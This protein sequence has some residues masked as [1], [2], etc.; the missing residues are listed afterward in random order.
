MSTRVAS[1]RYLMQSGHWYRYFTYL[2]TVAQTPIS[3]GVQSHSQS[4]AQYPSVRPPPGRP[5]S[6]LRPNPRAAAGEAGVPPLHGVEP[7]RDHRAGRRHGVRGSGGSARRPPSGLGAR[8]RFADRPWHRRAG[9]DGGRAGRGPGPSPAALDSVVRSRVLGRDIVRVKIC[10][11]PDGEVH[12]D[13]ISR[14][15]IGGTYILETRTTP[16]SSRWATLDARHQRPVKAGQNRFERGNGRRARGVP[17]R[18]G[19]VDR[20]GPCCSSSTSGSTRRASAH[21]PSGAGRLSRY[22]PRSRWCG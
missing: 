1:Y 18:Q 12:S 8:V 7:R 15:P 2:G 14:Q 13:R 10:S 21:S 17:P 11:N 9:A 16:P 6:P 4:A 5:R 20:A 3:G 19:G 22:S